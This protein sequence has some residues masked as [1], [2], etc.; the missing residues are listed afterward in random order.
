MSFDP[1]GRVLAAL[2]KLAGNELLQTL[3]LHEPVQKVAYYATRESVRAASELTRRF[4]SARKLMQPLRVAERRRVDDRFDL[5]LDDE[6]RMMREQVQRFAKQVMSELAHDADKACAAPEEFFRQFAELGLGPWIVPEGLG[7]AATEST[8][9]TQVLL[10]EDLAHG[11]MGLALAALAPLGV[12]NALTRWGSA[13]QQ[14]RYLAPF[15]GD[16]APIAALAIAEPRAVFD[17]RELRTRAQR[18]GD[19]FTLHG[20]KTLVPLAARAELFLVAADLLGCGPQL[21]L[22]EADVPGVVAKASPARGVRAAELGSLVLDNV[23]LPSAS[24]LAEDPAA[25]RYE[26]V[27]SRCAIGWSALAV[28]SAQ[29]VLD[30]VIPYCNERVAFGEPISHRQS[31]AFMIADIATELEGMRLLTWR[32]ATRAEHGESFAREAYLARL[33]CGE[34]GMRIGTDGVQLLGGHG[35]TKEHPV[36]RWY[37]DLRAISLMEGGLLL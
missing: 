36:E 24:L 16:R 17:P 13:S 27:L 8:T 9:M 37:R 32:A 20:E 14:A 18:D 21:F 29:A 3:G 35:F 33:L 34:K 12:A 7:G 23:R 19:G 6:Q 4:Q 26:E 28:G 1:M 2:N 22:I 30:Y 5:T 10:A 15:A 11:D 25:V 31:V